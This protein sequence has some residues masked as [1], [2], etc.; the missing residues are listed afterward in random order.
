MDQSPRRSSRLRQGSDDTSDRKLERRAAVAQMMAENME[1]LGMKVIAI[2]ATRYGVLPKELWDLNSVS[3]MGAE[4]GLAYGDG[5]SKSK[6]KRIIR[7]NRYSIVNLTIGREVLDRVELPNTLRR[8]E[9]WARVS[10]H[11]LAALDKLQELTL[12]GGASYALIIEPIVLPNSISKLRLDCDRPI[13]LPFALV[14]LEL[15]CGYNRPLTLPP[16]LERLAFARS[17]RFNLPLAFLQSLLSVKFG[18]LYNQPT[19]LPARIEEIRV[20]PAFARDLS[21]PSSVRKIEWHC[22][23]PIQLIYGVA[24]VE[25]GGDFA[26]PVLL[27]F[28]LKKVTFLGSWYPHRI[29]LPPGL[30]DLT[31]YPNAYVRGLVLPVGLKKLTWASWCFIELPSELRELIITGDAPLI[32]PE[33][34]LSIQFS[35]AS[36]CHYDLPESVQEVY[37]YSYTTFTHPT[38]LQHLILGYTFEGVDLSHLKINKLT[39]D[40]WGIRIRK[41]PQELKELAF[42]KDAI[43]GMTYPLRVPKG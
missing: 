18:D 25:F 28:S 20:G 35:G 21:F 22:N 41:W 39:I 42:I 37:S 23:R 12:H 14:E 36:P 6:F 19:S 7:N 2:M 1:G 5:L 32:L 33:G 8:L 31:W 4:R 34:L 26:Q 27:P 10:A 40:D 38:T 13:I 43:D 29:D 17:C 16:R 30:E 9:M 3:D 24:E 11:S 15:R